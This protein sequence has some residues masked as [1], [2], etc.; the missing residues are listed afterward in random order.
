[1]DTLAH[2]GQSDASLYLQSEETHFQTTP[3]RAELSLQMDEQVRAELSQQCPTNHLD[4]L[5]KLQNIN[6]MEINIC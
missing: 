4:A 6:N 3:V 1:M 5:G 2:S